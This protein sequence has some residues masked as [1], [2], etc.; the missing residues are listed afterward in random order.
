MSTFEGYMQAQEQGEAGRAMLEELARLYGCESNEK[1]IERQV[2]KATDCGAFIVF[3]VDGPLRVEI[4]S[5][6]EGTS[7]EVGPYEIGYMLHADDS[8]FI[9]RFRGT[10]EQVEDEANEIWHQVND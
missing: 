7:A 4:G 3:P 9:E 5:I 6:V 2:Y 8:S 1:A 10:I